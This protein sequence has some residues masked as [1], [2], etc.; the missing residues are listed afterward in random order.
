MVRPISRRAAIVA[1]V[2]GA[3]AV[4]AAAVSAC[5]A[6][7]AGASPNDA[8]QA[9]AGPNGAAPGAGPGDV[10]P[11]PAEVERAQQQLDER[12]SRVPSSVTSWG[13]DPAIGLVVVRVTGGR[14]PEVERFLD[15]IDPRTLR[16]VTGSDPV[17][18]LPGTG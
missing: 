18:P 17:R 1:A 13:I 15:G 4:T 6:A 10:R 7:Q 8:A 14:T 9:G 2:L 12:A 5:G 11:T 3:T 16:V